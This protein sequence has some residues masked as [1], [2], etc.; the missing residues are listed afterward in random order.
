MT[1]NTV[2]INRRALVS[3]IAAASA[4]NAVLPTAAQDNSGRRRLFLRR[5]RRFTADDVSTSK[6]G[7]AGPNEALR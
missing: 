4:L 5:L 6:C 1:K 2:G 3:G 7:Q